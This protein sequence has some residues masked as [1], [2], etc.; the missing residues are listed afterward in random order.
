M[1]FLRAEAYIRLNR[2]A[3]ALPI[4]NKT[5]V[6]NGKLPAATVTGVS[7]SRCVPRTITGACGDLMQALIYEKRLETLWLSAGLDFFDARGWGTLVPGTFVH[8][9]V[10]ALELA[11]L[12]MPVYT[13]GADAGGAAP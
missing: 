12:G 13:F 4:I 3:E 10:P 2:A 9:P 8:V 6:D 7:G 1:D 11:T 5:R